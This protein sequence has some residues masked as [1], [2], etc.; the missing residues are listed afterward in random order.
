[1]HP[2]E[3]LPY[4]FLSLFIGPNPNSKFR[5]SKYF[6]LNP[7]RKLLYGSQFRKERNTVEFHNYERKHDHCVPRLHNPGLQLWG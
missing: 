3:R 7:A 2:P 5:E 1:M 6:H 4:L